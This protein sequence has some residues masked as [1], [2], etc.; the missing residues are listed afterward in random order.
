MMNWEEYSN[1]F[2]QIEKNKIKKG[3]C[4]MKLS[5]SWEQAFDLW[6]K[7]LVYR[8]TIDSQKLDDVILNIEKKIFNF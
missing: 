2:P 3:E 6:S 8:H 1:F 4:K 5:L 7:L